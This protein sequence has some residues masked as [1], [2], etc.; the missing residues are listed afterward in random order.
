MSSFQN[1]NTAK[2][3]QG[4]DFSQT[5]LSVIDYTSITY[6]SK[7]TANEFDAFLLLFITGKRFCLANPES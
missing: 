2:K 7:S 5:I 6:L 1:L 4:I 3:C